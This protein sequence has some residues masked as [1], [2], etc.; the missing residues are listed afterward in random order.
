LLL[1]HRSTIQSQNFFLLNV[2]IRRK[3]FTTPKAKELMNHDLK[4]SLFS[5]MQDHD[6]FLVFISLCDSMR[7]YRFIYQ[8]KMAA[9]FNWFN[10]A[11]N[12]LRM[13]CC[14]PNL[15]HCLRLPTVSIVL[16]FYLVCCLEL[17]LN[18]VNVSTPKYIYNFGECVLKEEMEN[19]M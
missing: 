5:T 18:S 19:C 9:Y 2:R 4:A 12:S 16:V 11:L 17:T 6:S 1:L 13:Y 8:R 14:R 15:T 7:R 3:D 10:Q